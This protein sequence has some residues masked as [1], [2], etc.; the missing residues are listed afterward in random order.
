MKR[1]AIWWLAIVLISSGCAARQPGQALI[2]VW[3]EPPETP[4]IVF[5]HVLSGE[6][7]FRS[8]SFFRTILTI[9]G[10]PQPAGW[11]MRQPIA[12]AVTDGGERLYVA[13]YAQRVVAI[14]NFPEKKVTTLGGRPPLGL[15]IAVAVGP[16]DSLLVSDQEGRRL[17][18]FD[19]DG[20]FEK[21]IP[22]SEAERPTGLAVDRRRGRIYV[23][24]APSRTSPQHV[25]H[26][27]DIEGR[28]LM[29]IGKGAGHGE[30]F[31]H[32][33]TYVAVDENGRLYVADSMNS[34]ISCFEADGT[35]V[36][37][38]G[39]RGDRPGDFDK[40]KGIAFDTFGNLYAVDS[41]WSV[42]Q[43]MNPDGQMLLYFGGRHRLPGF[44]QNPTAITI[45]RNNRIYIADTL[46]FRVSVYDLINTTKDD[47]M[48]PVAADRESS[49][50]VASTS[51]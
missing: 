46:N 8:R 51:P 23:A 11:H 1:Y 28:Y 4:R 43:I 10:A 32:F 19:R 9:V 7:D 37:T 39:R 47:S 16:D 41:S 49:S 20:T 34:R 38:Y 29:D 33:P 50:S 35:F 2:P 22:I 17:L 15:P 14:F 48:T 24:D 3:P 31:L 26:V 6:S 30:G 40:P 13:D 27:Y 42:V 18:F 21:A 12:V 5:R 44:L 45:D 25:V 36:R